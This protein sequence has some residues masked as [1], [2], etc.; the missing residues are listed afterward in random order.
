MRKE[1]TADL[2]P[3]AQCHAVEKFCPATDSGSPGCG[4]SNK[5]QLSMQEAV[6]ARKDQP[7]ACLGNGQAGSVTSL[8]SD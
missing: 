2:K 6:T 3:L 5:S 1:R 8:L 7:R 4:E